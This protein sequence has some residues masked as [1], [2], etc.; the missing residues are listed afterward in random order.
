MTD[1][2]LDKYVKGRNAKEQSPA[3]EDDTIEV[4]GFGWLRGIRDTAIMLEIRH[5]DSH[6]TA[7]SYNVLDRAEFDPSDGITLKFAGVLVRITGRN[8]NVET[9]PHL[10]LFEGITRHRVSWIQEADEPTAMEAPK[11]ATV[12][13]EV[14]VK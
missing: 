10:R 7:F 6:I 9:R 11:E 4:P 5:R 1:D 3:D 12:I 2:V 8:L 14:E 13:E